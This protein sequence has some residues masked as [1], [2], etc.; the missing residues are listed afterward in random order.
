ML[1]LEK[2]TDGTQGGKPQVTRPAGQL[3]PADGHQVLAGLQ[4]EN[5]QRAAID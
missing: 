1:Y 3:A 4:L 5:V 2:L